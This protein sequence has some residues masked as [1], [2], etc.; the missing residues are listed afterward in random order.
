MDDKRLETILFSLKNEVI[1]E[2]DKKYNIADNSYSKISQK[3][4]DNTV[5]LVLDN[6]LKQA[7]ESQLKLMAENLELKKE[8]YELKEEI[9]N[10]KTSEESN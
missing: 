4:F 8:L 3:I 6:K 2:L 1:D 5:I 7:R 10:V 9:H